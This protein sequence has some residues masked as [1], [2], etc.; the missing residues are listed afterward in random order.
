M[1][2]IVPGD[3]LPL[4][5]G[6]L[7]ARQW[8]ALSETEKE[9]FFTFQIGDVLV[10]GD[11]PFEWGLQNPL[12]NLAGQYDGVTSLKVSSAGGNPEWVFPLGTGRNLKGR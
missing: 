5:R 3:R 2:V 10:W 6:Y 11:C 4:E 9:R 8:L 7:P 1:L 12:R